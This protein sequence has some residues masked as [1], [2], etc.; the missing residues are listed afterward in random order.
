MYGD[1][2]IFAPLAGD[3]LLLNTKT[4][5]LRRAEVPGPIC[6]S[7]AVSPQGTVWIGNDAGYVYSV[8]TD[9]LEV[10]PSGPFGGP[11]RSRIVEDRARVFVGVNGG[12][13]R[14]LRA[15]PPT[16]LYCVTAGGS[17]RARALVSDG[18]VLFGADDGEVR[19]VD[20]TGTVR[21][22]YATKGG[23]ISAQPAMGP[24]GLAYVATTRGEVLALRLPST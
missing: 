20:P 9:T 21:A 13:L 8:R 22:R 10:E 17:V 6:S 3:V 24:D 16:E 18:L 15:K 11:M 23:G 4:G 2:V 19:L 12:S 5:A 14:V 7:P 1:D